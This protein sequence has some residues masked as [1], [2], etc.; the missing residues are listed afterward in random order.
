MAFVQEDRNLERMN[1]P[2]KKRKKYKPGELDLMEKQRYNKWVREN[3]RPQIR[4][5]SRR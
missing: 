4:K 5:F 1:R 2:E 3:N